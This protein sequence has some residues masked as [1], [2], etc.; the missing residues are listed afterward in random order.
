LRSAFVAE[1]L[2]FGDGA[3]DGV[4][5]LPGLERNGIVRRVRAGSVTGGAGELTAAAVV[6]FG[7]LTS[8]F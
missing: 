2:T 7:L 8:D 5:L 1:S 4:G 3:G 6:A